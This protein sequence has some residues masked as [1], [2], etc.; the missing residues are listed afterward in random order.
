MQGVQVADRISLYQSV[1]TK[2]PMEKEQYAFIVG[3]L[4]HVNLKLDLIIESLEEKL[5]AVE[6]DEEFQEDFDI[7]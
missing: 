2:I 7:C 3:A 4:A 5:E 6:E 1:V